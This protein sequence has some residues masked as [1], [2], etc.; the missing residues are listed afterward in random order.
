MPYHLAFYSG[1]LVRISSEH[2]GTKKRGKETIQAEILLNPNLEE[3]LLRAGGKRNTVTIRPHE[4]KQIV[5]LGTG[6][7]YTGAMSVIRSRPDGFHPRQIPAINEEIFDRTTLLGSGIRGVFST[8]PAPDTERWLFR[9][10][11][12]IPNDMILDLVIIA[13]D[14]LNR[15]MVT[16][17]P[18]SLETAR[19]ALNTI[20]AYAF[21]ETFDT[22][23]N[24]IIPDIITGDFLV[25]LHQSWHF[26]NMTPG[27]SVSVAWPNFP[28]T[29][30]E[31]PTPITVVL[32][33]LGFDSVLSKTLYAFSIALPNYTPP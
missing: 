14:K 28:S 23:G 3:P 9:K 16:G 2:R 4:K 29:L 5:W 27:I 13:V 32:V 7:M 18:T 24:Q 26:L 31:L 19:I 1:H 11:F 10:S 33:G 30:R 12:I 17:T 20:F 6:Y 8:L 22:N 25:K 15:F 21:D